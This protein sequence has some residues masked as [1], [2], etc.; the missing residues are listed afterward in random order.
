MF[1]RAFTCMVI[2]YSEYRIHSYDSNQTRRARVAFYQ[3]RE[4]SNEREAICGIGLN[5]LSG[6]G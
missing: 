6:G 3:V 1:R 2:T 4:V 5:E